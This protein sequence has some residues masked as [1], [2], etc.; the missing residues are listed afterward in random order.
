V[1]SCKASKRASQHPGL[2]SQRPEYEETKADKYPPTVI[3]KQQ[4]LHQKN[5]K[6]TFTHLHLRF[7][8]NTKQ[9]N[10][11][12]LVSRSPKPNAFTYDDNFIEWQNFSQ[13]TSFTYVTC[14][15]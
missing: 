5:A 1:W 14:D 6:D 9:T 15:T 13:R 4:L 10:Y 3:K 8:L 7:P 12:A 11:F 2:T